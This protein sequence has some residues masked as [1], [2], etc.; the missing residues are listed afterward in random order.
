GSRDCW[1]D[2]N[3]SSALA[4]IQE[5]Y[6]HVAVIEV[7]AN[8]LFL[9]MTKGRCV[10]YPKKGTIWAHLETGTWVLAADNQ[11]A[12][13]KLYK[14]MAIKLHPDKQSGSHEKFIKLTNCSENYEAIRIRFGAEFD[15]DYPEDP[16]YSKYH[17]Y[18]ARQSHEWFRETYSSYKAWVKRQ[19]E[20]DEYARR[21]IEELGVPF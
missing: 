18:T 16:K 13:R 21:Q 19:K 17:Y 5:K 10:F 3:Y 15:D 6:P 7:W 8:V 11:V 2:M 9:R 4:V 20:H 14:Q 1:V 12:A